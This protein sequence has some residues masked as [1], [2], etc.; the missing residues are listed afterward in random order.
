MP[1]QSVNRAYSSVPTLS[2]WQKYHFWFF[3]LVAAL[4]REIPIISI[5]FNW[6]ES[7]FHEIS[8]GIAALATGGNIVRIQLFTNGAGLCTT[9]GGS[10]FMISFFGY[11]GAIIWGGII[12]NI[13]GQHQRI[14]Q[15]FTGVIM[16]LLVCSILFWVRDLLT[17]IILVVLLL[18]F[19]MTIKMKQL[20]YL[21]TFIQL[22]GLLVLLNSFF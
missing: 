14:A 13:A 1:E 6:L 15:V 12:Y 4:I 17:L 2:F 8:H 21:Q 19:F 11:A 16:V 10:A 22:F 20:K 18:M 3:L 9:Q 7:Y 5:P